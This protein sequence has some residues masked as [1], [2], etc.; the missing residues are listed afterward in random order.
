[1]K[2]CFLLARR[3]PPRPSPILLDVFKILRQRGLAVASGIP[4]EAV[5]R[6][7]QMRPEHDLYL[8]KSHTEL[9]QSVAGVLYD[10]GARLLNPFRSCVITQDKILASRRLR[11]AGIPTPRSWITGE[12]ARLRPILDETPLI[13]KPHRGHR[14]AGIH[15]VRITCNPYHVQGTF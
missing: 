11:A 4:E 5:T 6:P 9:A 14:G 3:V 15:L 7:D 12:P 8:L 10:Q 2:L 13:I 1:M